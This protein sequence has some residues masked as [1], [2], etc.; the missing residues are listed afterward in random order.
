MIRMGRGPEGAANGSPN[1]AN[2]H[3][4][5]GG[6]LISEATPIVSHHQYHHHNNNTNMFLPVSVVSGGERLEPI[7]NVP[8]E[9][10]GLYEYDG[11]PPPAYHE[12]EGQVGE[13][14]DYHVHQ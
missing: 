13:I 2:D 3:G 4:Y 8:N 11:P 1:D 14:E 5:E 10:D 12:V 6:Y 7:L 9:H